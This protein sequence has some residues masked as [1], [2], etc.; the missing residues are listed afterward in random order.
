MNDYK[1][2]TSFAKIK[3]LEK[4]N[5]KFTL[6]E[7]AVCACGKNRNFFYLSKDTI[8]KGLSDLDYLPIVAHLMKKEDGSGYYIGGHDYTIEVDGNAVKYVPETQIVGCVIANSS[9]FKEIEEFGK[10]VTYLMC[11]CILYTEHIPTLMDAI[12]NENVWFNQS[13]EI[14]IGET[15]PLEEDN[16]YCEVLEFKFLKLCLLGLS[17]NPS[18]NTEP[19]FIS[20]K[21]KPL[22]YAL[23]ENQSAEFEAMLVSIKECITA[24]FD[25][26]S[27][28]GGEGTKMEDIKTVE[29]QV[30]P[31]V[32]DGAE[33]NAVAGDDNH[34]DDA[35][36]VPVSFALAYNE[37]R[38]KLCDALKSECQYDSDG[39][40]VKEICRYLV[41]F[42]DTHVIA[43]KYAYEATEGGCDRKNGF[44]RIEYTEADNEIA[45]GAEETVYM[46]YLSAD[47]L[48]AVEDAEAAKDAELSELREFKRNAD[49]QEK[50]AVLNSFADIADTAEFAALKEH[51][52][53]YA[54]IADIKK[55]CFAIR[56]MNVK[57]Q[58]PASLASAQIPTAE[59]KSEIEDFVETYR[60]K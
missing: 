60:N 22:T 37:K 29:E 10:K 49:E 9:E 24:H 20:S 15:R 38:N 34:E 40:L 28:K 53:D 33:N 18:Y 30:I 12:Y 6:A 54:D 2:L 23:D 35:P 51:I 1:A 14:E 19:C 45:L 13:M 44:V 43:E 26:R 47:E 11:K 57:I 42:D 55:E 21:V 41:D 39:R 4:L 58:K 25:K 48:K 36:V 52:G 32:E 50:E 59:K 31:V 7:C 56:G 16:N 46:R 8:E 5:D 17:D 3:P 27:E